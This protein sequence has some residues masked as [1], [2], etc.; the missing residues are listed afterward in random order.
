MLMINRKLFNRIVVLAFGAMCAAIMTACSM[1][2]SPYTAEEIDKI[3]EYSALLIAGNDPDSS[4]LVDIKDEFAPEEDEE[5]NGDEIN[6]EPEVIEEPEG[7][8]ETGNNSPDINIVDVSRNDESNVY[9]PTLEEFMQLP[10]G[11]SVTY[12]GYEW[13]ESLTNES[14]SY[15]FDPDDGNYFLILNYTIYNAS[16]SSQDI[17]FLYAGYAFNL[18]INDEKTVVAHEIPINEDLPTYIGRLSDGT[19]VNL[20]ITFE[21]ASSYYN[22]IEAMRLTVKTI[23]SSCTIVLE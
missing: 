21:C 22:N 23:D 16:G 7:V 13:K 18:R 12:K 5:E 4:R 17:N 19:G 10:E 20:M 2:D 1:G 3:G 11:V 8:D 6:E 14:G 9:Q 15:F